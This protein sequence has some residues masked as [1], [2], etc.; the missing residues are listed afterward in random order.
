[1]TLEE[2]GKQIADIDK[3][4]EVLIQR[5]RPSENCRKY[6]ELRT[7]EAIQKS[8]DNKNEYQAIA[9]VHNE[10]IKGKLDGSIFWKIA[11]VLFSLITGSYV[12]TWVVFNIL[13][14]SK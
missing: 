8:N 9:K 14:S 6:V 5:E 10:K 3:K 11:S 7:A 12:F 13:G 4:V 1:M 2:L